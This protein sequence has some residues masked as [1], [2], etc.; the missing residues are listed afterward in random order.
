M[1]EPARA[2]GDGTFGSGTFGGGTL[3][4]R[5]RKKRG[6]SDLH[7]GRTARVEQRRVIYDNYRR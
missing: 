3:P 6:Y 7:M 5:R 4:G 2:F 1:S